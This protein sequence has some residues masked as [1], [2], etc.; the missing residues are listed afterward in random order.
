MKSFVSGFF[1]L[2]FVSSTLGDVPPMPLQEDATPLPA[3]DPRPL[4]ENAQGGR[5][6]NN[7]GCHFGSCQSQY[8]N[9]LLNNSF[10]NFK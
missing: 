9:C 2:V 7:V 8:V 4:Q 6:H 10:G 3:E 5:P 1:L